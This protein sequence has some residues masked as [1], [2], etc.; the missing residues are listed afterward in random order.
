MLSD[1]EHRIATLTA[2]IQFSG[3]RPTQVPETNEHHHI[4]NWHCE[5]IN[6]T[7]FAR[8]VITYS[9]E[10]PNGFTVKDLVHD[11]RISDVA[12]REMIN[13]SISQDWLAKN[14][15]TNTYKVTEYS[16]E[17]N[18]KYVK[19]HMATCQAW[20]AELNSLLTVYNHDAVN[21]VPYFDPTKFQ[22]KK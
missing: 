6:R 11:L 21:G 12:V 2:K 10:K 13:Y 16:L 1:I 20:I 15:A 8:R 5:T 14:V 3:N 7:R 9:Y 4:H 17:H 19:A 22:E 18:F